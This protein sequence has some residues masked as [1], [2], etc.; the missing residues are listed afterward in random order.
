MQALDYLVKNS[1][2]DHFNLGSGQGFTVQEIIE[3]AR[4]VT[5]HAIPAQIE[6]RCVIHIV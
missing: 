6:E 5:G 2:S 3:A 1:T 4:R